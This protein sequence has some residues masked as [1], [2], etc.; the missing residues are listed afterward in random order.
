M[1]TCERK[2]DIEGERSDRDKE[3]K[4]TDLLLV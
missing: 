4:S 2:R 1:H 3:T